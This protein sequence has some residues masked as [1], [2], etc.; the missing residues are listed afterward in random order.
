MVEPLK[1]TIVSCM[2]PPQDSFTSTKELDIKLA[3]R[4]SFFEMDEMEMAHHLTA[5]TWSIY[6]KLKVNAT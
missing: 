6:S 2:A 1:Q 5:D 4:I 3:T